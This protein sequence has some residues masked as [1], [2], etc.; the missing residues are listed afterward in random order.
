MRERVRDKGRLCDIIE[1]ADKALEIIDG[2]SFEAFVKDIAVYYAVMK[3]VEI[4][5]EAT[6]MLTND[7]KQLHPDISWSRIQG[8]RHVLVHGYAQIVPETLY[9]TT[10]NDLPMFRNQVSHFLEE[11]DW[12][13]WE[14]DNQLQE[15]N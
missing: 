6:Y 7:F 10:I 4:V 13:A 1:H 12:D 14:Q 8:L 3:C 11:T 15:S 5:G 2:R 9:D